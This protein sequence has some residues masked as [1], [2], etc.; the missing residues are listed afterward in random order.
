M[1]REYGYVT[2]AQLL[3]GRFPRY[4]LL[5]W[6]GSL[7]KIPTWALFAFFGL[8]ILVYAVK[9]VPKAVDYVRATRRARAA[10]V[11][12]SGDAGAEERAAPEAAEGND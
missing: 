1:G 8:V 6:L 3:V 5:A 11:A 7:F 10:R 9:A 2:Q 12:E 4:V